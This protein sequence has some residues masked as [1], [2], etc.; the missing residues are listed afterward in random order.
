M[1]QYREIRANFDRQ[2]IVMYQAYGPAIA[3]AALESGRFVPPFSY[4]R[5]TWI[6]PSFLWLMQRSNLGRKHQQ[7]QL[8][9]AIRAGA[10]ARAVGSGTLDPGQEAG[11]SSDPSGT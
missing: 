4:G 7:R 9:G 8:A 11:P 10:G 2:T 6:K 1:S 3:D 5:M